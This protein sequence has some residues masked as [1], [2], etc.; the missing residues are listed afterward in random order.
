[1]VGCENKNSH[2]IFLGLNERYNLDTLSSSLAS[3]DSNNIKSITTENVY[4]TIL[5]WSDSLKSKWFLK[6]LSNNLR[7]DG[8][9][10]FEI[11]KHNDSIIVLSLGEE[12]II[13]GATNGYIFLL[14]Y[15][16]KSQDLIQLL[17]EF[18]H[19]NK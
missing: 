4:R 5:E 11:T 2:K 8:N 18:L 10:I 7:D 12:D 1:L 16:F 15:P 9:G 3:L 6:K 14:G 17:C 19:R 13:V